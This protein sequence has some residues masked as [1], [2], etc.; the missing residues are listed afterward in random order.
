[1][2][3]AL[4]IIP[5]SLFILFIHIQLHS[6]KLVCLLCL[7]KYVIYFILQASQTVQFQALASQIINKTLL[8]LLRSIYLLCAMVLLL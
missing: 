4:F 7:Q 8:L 5:L 2:L 3:H 6:L 1:M